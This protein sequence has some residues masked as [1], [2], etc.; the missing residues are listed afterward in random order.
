MPT[1][2]G[3]KDGSHAADY[4]IQKQD[5]LEII[6]KKFTKTW[7]VLAD[8]VDQDDDSILGA[9]GIPVLYTLSNGAYTKGKKAK[10]LSRVRHPVSG[11][12]TELW[13]VKVD[14]D[15]SIDPNQDE[16]DPTNKP[17]I[18]RWHGETEDELLEKDPI[19]GDP[20]ETDA[21]EPILITTPYVMPVL[22]IKRYESYPFNPNTMLNYSHRVNSTAFWGAAAGTALM[23]PME[24]DQ[25]TIEGTIYAIVTYRIKFKIKEGI[26]EPWKARLLHHGFKYRPA[27]GAKP[28]IFKDK[29]GNPAT[30]N[31]AAGGTLLADGA[32]ADYKE[33][34]R[35]TKA[36]LNDL[37][38]GPF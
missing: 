25:E 21:G 17:A 23:L 4:S 29:H 35:F 20:I 12:A 15:S 32:A 9:S 28:E 22:E 1:V 8:S 27:A 36:N 38:L 14:F 19:T 7:Y 34:N 6:I 26:D 30:V 3:V 10:V 11:T 31:L 5:K 18:I 16:E 33:F 24:V 13:E 37:S 2:I